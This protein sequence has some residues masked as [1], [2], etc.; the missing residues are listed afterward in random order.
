MIGVGATLNE[1][2]ILDQE[3]GQGGMGTVY[4]ATDQLLGRSV[5]IKFLKDSGTEKHARQIRLE[6]QILARLLH[7]KIVRLYDFGE[8]DGNYFLVMEEVD[9]LSFAHRL[10][11][12]GLGDRLRIC[13]Q[14]AEALDY[15]HIQGVI[16]RDVKPGNVLL[17]STD[18]AKLSDFGLSFVS[19][20]RTDQSA[21]IRGTPSYMSPEQAQGKSLD[22]RTDLYSVGVMAYECATGVVPF[23]G[24]MMSVLRQHASATPM[25]P[26]LKNPEISSTLE[27]LILSLLEKHPTRRPPSGNVVALALFE[28]AERAR[29]LERINPG[30]RRSDAPGPVSPPPSS[31]FTWGERNGERSGVNGTGRLDPAPV[32]PAGTDDPLA[33]SHQFSN[34][35]GAPPSLPKKAAKASRSGRA[36]S[37]GSSHHPVAREM[38]TS[39]LATP[40]VISPEERYLCGH[41]LAYLLGGSRRRGFF[42]RRPLDALNSDRARLVLAMTWLS[43]AEPTDDAIKRASLLLEDRPD[44]RGELNPIVVIKYLASRDTVGKRKRFRQLRKRLQEASPYARKAMLDGNGVL[45]PGLMPRNLEDLAMIAPSRDT[46]DGHRVSLWNRVRDVWREEDDFRQAVLRYATRSEQLDA[47]S[48]DLWPE[49]VYPLIERAHWQRKFRPRHEAIWDYLVG[50]LLHVPVA[51]VRLDRMMVI[52]IP[53][54]VALQLDLDLWAVVDDPQIDEE[55]GGPTDTPP[56]GQ[57]RPFY[58]GATIP[59]DERPSDEDDDDFA[60]RVKPKV[61]LCAP[62]PILFTQNTLRNLWE[63]A[64]EAHGNGNGQGPRLVH[65][66]VPVGQYELAVI[67]TI[68]GRARSA[69]RAVLQGM[70]QGK[71][72]E[73]FTPSALERDSGSRPVIAIWIYQD[74]SIAVVHIDFQ[75]KERFILWHAPD[76]HQFNFDYREELIQRLTSVNLDVPDKLE[77][78]LSESVMKQR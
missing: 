12:L 58:F 75:S 11:S 61:P 76:G 43:Q 5:A 71:Q 32:A 60:P 25:S 77:K 28:E 20:D 72:I 50:K 15:A 3:L 66:T 17:T 49:V 55:E 16:H 36:S 26:R 39:V 14:V 57:R 38:L 48:T 35:T 21:T 53:R 47:V 34:T 2:F 23:V 62:E 54:E 65:R 70:T 1:R 68:R 6:A 64:L 37:S 44:V 40:V 29:R 69:V 7:D 27:G 13:A 24:P 74:A 9:G 73:I 19:A 31:T 41:Y 33:A 30:L 51:G 45:N 8:A 4:R 18:D 67:P 52:A 63:G 46:L 59:R 56:A 10:Q 42:L 22:H 78:A